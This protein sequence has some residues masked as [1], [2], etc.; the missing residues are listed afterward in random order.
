M[1]YEL[2]D[3]LLGNGIDFDSNPITATFSPSSRRTVV[4]IPLTRDVVIEQQEMFR[5]NL[6]LDT[7]NPSIM[8]GSIRTAT[9][10]IEDSTGM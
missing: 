5:I 10:I 7:T 8:L 3:Y 6:M 1:Y 2:L 9:G 4:W